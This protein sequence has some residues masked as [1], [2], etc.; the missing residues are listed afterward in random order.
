MKIKDFLFLQ[1]AIFIYSLSN[2]FAKYASNE[3]FLSLRYI[4]FM[5]MLTGCLGLYAIFWQQILKKIPLSVA[6]CFNGIA[7]LWSIFLGYAMF[8]EAVT[9]RSLIGAA[10]IIA[11]VIVMSIG[12][13]KDE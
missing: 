2:V 1:L 11:G 9:A 3:S 8:N 12:G 13:Q 10:F 6:Y 7:I 5:G 4:L